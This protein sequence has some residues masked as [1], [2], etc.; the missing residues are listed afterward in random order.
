MKN[1]RLIS[2]VLVITF[3][4]GVTKAQSLHSKNTPTKDNILSANEK[5]EGF[6]L[7]WNGK[8]T[9]G[10]RAIFKDH[11]PEKGWQIKDGVLTVQASN[12]QEQGSGG[13]IVTVKEYSAFILK[14]DFKLTEGANSGVK[15]FVTEKE[16]TKN[17][18][19]GLEYQYWTTNVILMQN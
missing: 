4:V 2:A 6:K 17:S 1:Y 13:D 15:Y 12:G 10:W 5:K 19:I 16:K 18:G 3:A 11:F 9:K 14:F 8:D 7:L